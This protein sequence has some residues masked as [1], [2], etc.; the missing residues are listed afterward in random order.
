[1]GQVFVNVA[2]LDGTF[3]ALS[4]LTPTL[5]KREREQKPVAL[6]QSKKL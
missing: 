4:A 3:P 5:S 1:M 2:V 6:L